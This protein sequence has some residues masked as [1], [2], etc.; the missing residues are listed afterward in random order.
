MVN[1]HRHSL[2]I[3]LLA[4]A[5]VLASESHA[6]PA[7]KPA[8]LASREEF[9]ELKIR[10]LLIAKCED[11]HTGQPDAES[12]LTVDS[13]KSLLAGGDFGPAIF[14]GRSADSVLIQAVKW[15]HK[16]L[17]MPPDVGDRLSRDEIVALARWIDDGA[18][19]PASDAATTVV[20]AT[21]PIRGRRI[22]T[23]HWSFQP[24]RVTSPPAVADTR[25]SQ[26]GIDRFVEDARRQRDLIAVNEADRHTLIRR[27]TFDLI[28]LPPTPEEVAA[29]VDETR[30]TDEAYAAVVDRLLGSPHYGERW[31]RHWLDVARYADTQGDVGDI[32]I[33]KAWLY[34]NWVID[35]LNADMPFDQFLRAQVAGDVLAADA[36]KRG[37]I[38]D[39]EARELVVATGFIALAQRYGNSKPEHLHLTIENTIDTLGRGVLGL[40]L[41][42][43]RCHD[44]PFDPVLQ[45]DYYGLYGIL[46][47]TTYPWM[48]MSIEKSPSGL[49]PARP[50]PALQRQATAYW[51]T[52]SRHE[53]Q[54]NNHFRPWLKPTLDEFKQVT[55]KLDFARSSGEPPENTVGNTS[56]PAELRKLKQ[57]REEL[58]AAHDG[59]FRELMQHGLVWLRQEKQRLAESPPFEMVFAASEGKSH[60]ANIQRR[61]EP[62]RPGPMVPRRFLQV[63]DGPDAPRIETG[64]GRRELAEWLTRPDHPLLPRVIVNRIWQRHFGRGLVATSDNLGVRGEKPSHPELLDWLAE[65]FIQDGWSLKKLHRRMV[66][67]RT[68]RLTSHAIGF[69]PVKQSETAGSEP[70][71]REE[72]DP[73]NVY[74]WRFQRRRL[75]AEAIRDAMLTVSGRL[76]RTQAQAHPFPAWHEKRYGLNG[77]FHVEFETNHRSVYLMTQRLFDHSFLGLFDAPDT[78]STTTQRASADVAGQALFLMNS[79]FIHKQSEAFADRL[80]RERANDQQ[81]IKFAFKLAY[82]RAADEN[83]QGRFEAYIERFRAIA[84]ANA[85]D[86]SVELRAW[87]SIARAILTSNEFFF[88]D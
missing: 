32:P 10:P 86:N 22:E 14:P 26:N 36:L 45:T 66:M 39:R 58:L 70:A 17:R 67:T 79:P 55:K 76:D 28:G 73:N 27:V 12:E 74:L 30:P 65:Q 88:V 61:G 2:A 47:S 1:D 37:E 6:G 77:P 21:E 7:S 84:S 29:F 63:V 56:E 33:P 60:D 78:N 87:T 9:F 54:I 5:L 81:R 35:S 20:R 34:R 46:D 48:G 13:R 64:S 68:Y 19:W 24:R 18:A 57:R 16:E 83:E 38:D 42:C 52:I 15:T 50:D 75:E 23:N 44:H 69:H 80:L 62:T 72:I 25:W 71:P 59:R 43:S 4:V 3:P 40:T 8:S 53:Y 51:E 41:R 82:G 31:G 49:A 11:C 85:D